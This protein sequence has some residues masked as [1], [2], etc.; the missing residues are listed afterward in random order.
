M[1]LTYLPFQIISPHR[2]SQGSFSL[3]KTK[4]FSVYVAGNVTWL[5]HFTATRNDTIIK[6]CESRKEMY[7]CTSR[8]KMN[9]RSSI[10]ERLRFLSL[11]GQGLG[12]D[13]HRCDV[14]RIGLFWNM[15]SS[16]GCYMYYIGSTK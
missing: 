1:P 14:S 9:S 2:R 4:K 12:L 7:Y 3:F 15:S 6:L 16:T 10:V 13:V 11:T 8:K 5:P